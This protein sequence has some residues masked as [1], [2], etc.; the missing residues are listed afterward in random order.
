MLKHTLQNPD[1]DIRNI[2]AQILS[3]I[4]Q[5]EGFEAIEIM[6]NKL[7]KETLQ[8]LLKSIPEIKIVIDNASKKKGANKELVYGKQGAQ[9]WP[10]TLSNRN[11][12]NKKSSIQTLNKNTRFF[13][14]KQLSMKSGGMSA[15]HTMDDTEEDGKSIDVSDQ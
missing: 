9:G 6:A 5:R 8:L 7:H 10:Y 14:Q 13:S 12:L 1:K 4:Y 11:K 3:I 15:A 2:S